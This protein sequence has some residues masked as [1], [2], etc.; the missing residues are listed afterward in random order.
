MHA[1]CH[2]SRYQIGLFLLLVNQIYSGVR[3]KKKKKKINRIAPNWS[4][5]LE[6]GCMLDLQTPTSGSLSNKQVKKRNRNLNF[7]NERKKKKT[8]FI[9]SGWCEDF[10]LCL[11]RAFHLLE[12]QVLFPCNMKG[13]TKK[14]FQIKMA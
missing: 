13:S 8:T 12:W 3:V 11:A 14:K 9:L 4:I 10:L 2:Q 7:I 5:L 6:I 1:I